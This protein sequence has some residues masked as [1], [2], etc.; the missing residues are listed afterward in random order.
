[1][2][3]EYFHVETT[4]LVLPEVNILEIRD[5]ARKKKVRFGKREY[6]SGFW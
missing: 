2:S 1:M 6:I 5:I 4:T 3:M